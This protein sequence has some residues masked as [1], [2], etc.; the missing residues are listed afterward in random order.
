MT[1]A[2]SSAYDAGAAAY[3][4]FTG[5][6][7][8]LYVPCLVAAAEVSSG[9]SVLDVAAG[10]GEATVGLASCVGTTGRLLAVDLSVPMLRVAV[11]KVAGPR[12]GV[13]VMDGQELA[14]RDRSFDAV[15]CQLGLMFFPA[16]LRGLE[17]CRRVLRPGGRVA[18]LVWS[19]PE[20]VPYF[21]I[22][23]D[24]LSRHLPPAQH[25]ALYQPSALADADRLGE[26]LTRA[27]F[28]EVSVTPERRRRA[29]GSFEDYWEAIEAGA[30]RLGP[31]YLGLPETPRRAVREE[32]RQR[33]APFRS[34]AGLILEAE[35]LIGKGVRRCARGGD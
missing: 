26:L 5:Q 27:G 3:D 14:C 19:R 16:P 28:H 2:M 22:L 21:G 18:L 13:A 10:T 6:W 11:T 9:H 23:A 24:A 32:V 25:D 20:R 29:F 15:V 31:L 33:M 4:R 30:G 8:R 7:S 35:A 17:E 12:V 1:A 34:G